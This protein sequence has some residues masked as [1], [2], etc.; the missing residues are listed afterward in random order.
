MYCS[1]H[2]LHGSFDF[3]LALSNLGY[4]LLCGLNYLTTAL[5]G[6]V[7]VTKLLDGWPIVF[8]QLLS[9]SNSSKFVFKHFKMTTIFLRQDSTY[10]VLLGYFQRIFV[11]ERRSVELT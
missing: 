3:L 6:L 7:D 1:H 4:R 9:L 11:Q 2:L 8:E 10:R 5:S